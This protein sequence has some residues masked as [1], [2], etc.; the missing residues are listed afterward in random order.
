MP[1]KDRGYGNLSLNAYW[2]GVS[3]MWNSLH[4]I[5]LPMMLLSLVSEE[6]KNTTYGL[7]TF[8]GLMIAL[9]VQPLSGA[10]S[11]HTR[12]PMGRRRP[13][14]L[15]GTLLDIVWLF[16]LA[17]A[18]SW[19]VVAIGYVLLQASSNLA[20]G[21]AQGLIPDIVP[22]S[23]RGVASGIKVFFDMAGVILASLVAGRLVG[24]DP[25][26]PVLVVTVIVIVLLASAMI[27]LIG[28]REIPLNE[29]RSVAESAH[30]S[31]KSAHQSAKSALDQLRRLLTVDLRGQR[32]Y[33]RLLVSRFCVLLGTYSVQSFALYYFRDGL[34]LEA[35]AR[36]VGNLMA[37]I[38]LSIAVAA[39][40]AG[41]LS[42]RW[43]RKGLSLAACAT[44][45]VGTGLLCLVHDLK[46]LYVLGCLI[47]LSMGTFASVNWA[48]A[49]D[50]VP[51][52]EAGKYLGLSNLATAGSAAAS[53]LLGPLIDAINARVPNGGYVMLF[54]LATV[55]ALAGLIVTLGITETRKVRSEHL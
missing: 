43:G 7:L 52:A 45:G 54:V 46:A 4:P 37:T 20:H 12:H 9:V 29:E 17:L 44:V 48:W 55:G 18:R 11:D 34:Q 8:A 5:L 35:P 14:I 24:G 36:A 40:P 33:T 47:G 53:R 50:L 27:T 19:W 26:R 3:F 39:Y 38:A 13:W 28:V 10:L 49:T 25:P 21:P 2:F 16:T 1:R 51:A 6:I 41:A 15:W 42:E 32:D 31:A 23:E 30:Q 22:E